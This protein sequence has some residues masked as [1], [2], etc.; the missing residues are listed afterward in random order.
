[1]SQFSPLTTAVALGALVSLSSCIKKT[2]TFELP[3]FSPS[4]EPVAAPAQS[5]STEKNAAAAATTTAASAGAAVS[6]ED[7]MPKPV[8]Y[9]TA[10]DVTIYEEAPKGRAYEVLGEVSGKSS[11]KIVLGGSEDIMMAHLQ[12]QAKKMGADAIIMKSL[13]KGF[14]GIKKGSDRGMHPSSATAT[15]I[16][17]K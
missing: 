15:A 6:D 12:V 2:Y 3:S 4:L 10:D 11:D 7:S 8:I 14:L 5:S 17:F 9:Y 16:K 1:M 13:E